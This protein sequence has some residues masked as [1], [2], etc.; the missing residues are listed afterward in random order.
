MARKLKKKR[1]KRTPHQELKKDTSDWMSRYVRLR[2][3]KAADYFIKTSYGIGYVMCY[4]CSTVA[5]IK[6][7]HAGH[8]KS[9][10]SGGNSGIYF[11][12]CGVHTQCRQCNAFEQGKPAEFREHLIR[13]YDVET[14]EEL[15][16]KHKLPGG[17][18]TK[19]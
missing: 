3:A 11:N 17:Y 14:V 12:E 7:M 15:E 16:L 19:S 6:N 2:D 18:T 9:R 10:G 8:Y 4:T 5:H 1:K 13:D